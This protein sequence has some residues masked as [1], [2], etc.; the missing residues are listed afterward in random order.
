MKVSRSVAHSLWNYIVRKLS[1]LYVYTIY[2]ITCVRTCI[3][4][5]DLHC[6]RFG[7]VCVRL[8]SHRVHSRKTLLKLGIVPVSIQRCI[9]AHNVVILQNIT[10]WSA[11]EAYAILLYVTL[12]LVCDRYC[13]FFPKFIAECIF[14]LQIGWR[15]LMVWCGAL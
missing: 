9:V 8:Q 11:F 13:I 3:S 14:F 1:I 12:A 6:M 7:L 15:W 4:E 5:C 10:W 2:N